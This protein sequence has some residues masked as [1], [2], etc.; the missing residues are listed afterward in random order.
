MEPP[1]GFEPRTAGYFFATVSEFLMM[2][3]ALLS[4]VVGAVACTMHLPN[5]D[6]ACR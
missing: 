4:E 3:G 2:K 1:R 6:P 5:L